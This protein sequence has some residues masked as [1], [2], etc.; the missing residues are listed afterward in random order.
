[1][2]KSEE[3]ARGEG[4]EQ[5]VRGGSCVRPENIRVGVGLL[6]WKAPATLRATLESHVSKDLFSL[7]D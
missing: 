7:F 5:G 4:E 2:A 1:M 3:K 6:S